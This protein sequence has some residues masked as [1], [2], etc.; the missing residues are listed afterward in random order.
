MNRLYKREDGSYHIYRPHV[1]QAPLA[2]ILSPLS[3]IT[4][5]N[6]LF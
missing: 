3:H 2:R 6:N 4:M 1:H 5:A